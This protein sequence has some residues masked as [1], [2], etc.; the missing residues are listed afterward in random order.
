MKSRNLKYLFILLSLFSFY[1]LTGQSLMEEL[2]IKVSDALVKAPL[3]GVK[4]SI[5]ELGY[6]PVKKTDSEGTAYFEGVPFKRIEILVE[7]FPEFYPK[8]VS[9]IISENIEN[10][11]VDIQLDPV[12]M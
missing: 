5:R 11:V 12:P 4:I 6:T 8:R 10:N 1:D 2:I 3:P 7:K 9:W